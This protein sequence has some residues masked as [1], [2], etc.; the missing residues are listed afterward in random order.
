[1][2]VE[3]VQSPGEKDFLYLSQ[4]MIP[5]ISFLAMK[6]VKVPYSFLGQFLLQFPLGGVVH[7]FLKCH[8]W[9]PFTRNADSIA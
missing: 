7:F 6:D 8:G 5:Q 4:V 3:V 2:V 1:M 9:P